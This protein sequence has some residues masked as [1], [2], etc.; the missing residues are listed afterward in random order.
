MAQSKSL[1]SPATDQGQTH[2]QSNQN[3]KAMHSQNVHPCMRPPINQELGHKRE[4]NQI[5]F[6]KE[7]SGIPDELFHALAYAPVTYIRWRDR[8]PVDGAHPCMNRI[9]APDSGVNKGRSKN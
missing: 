4:P 5:K 8:S 9:M 7:P 2:F 6:V 3:N 1:P